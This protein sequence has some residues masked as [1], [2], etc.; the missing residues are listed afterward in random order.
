MMVHSRAA[1]L[2]SRGYVVA[3]RTVGTGAAG[4]EYRLGSLPQSAS[5]P[6]NGGV[7]AGPTGADC[8]SDAEQL[9]I[10]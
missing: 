4:S 1:E 8:E 9:V 6:V 7:G 10:A 2:R 3:H 5:S